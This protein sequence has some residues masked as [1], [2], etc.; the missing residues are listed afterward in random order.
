MAQDKEI[1]M[2]G[3]TL[4]KILRLGRLVRLVRL[5][6]FK[7][8]NELRMM[9][10]GVFSGLTVLFWA[11]TLL[12]VCIFVLGTAARMIIGDNRE[13]FSSMYISMLTIFRC[14]TDGCTAHD[15]TPL[16]NPLYEL[17][18]P[19]FAFMY[20]V[21]YLA[22]TIGL[23]NLIMSIFIQTVLESGSSRLQH[24][25]GDQRAVMQNRIDSY[26][27]RRFVESRRDIPDEASE[28]EV[29]NMFNKYPSDERVVDRDL[30]G[31]WVQRDDVDELL[32]DVKVDP[33]TKCYLFDALDFECR[34]ELD[35]N[36]IVAGLMNLRGPITKLDVVATRLKI[37]HIMRLT[38]DICHK[39]GIP[40]DDYNLRTSEIF[41]MT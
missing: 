11:L 4:I 5:L 7:A 10:E 17:Y 34:G 22:V 2:V 38:M 21:L 23:F 39:L 41:G 35:V 37:M 1:D 27:T 19:M 3:V 32:D 25:L 20:F 6:Q 28:D 8:F 18:G 40:I 31:L 33:S 14:V 30:F 13:E 29:K 16:Q 15:G 24:Q 36:T 9:V 26:F 12:A